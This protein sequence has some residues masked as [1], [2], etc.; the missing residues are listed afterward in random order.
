MPVFISTR[1]MMRLG[2]DPALYTPW[3][4]WFAWYP[5]SEMNCTYW[6]VWVEWRH[7]RSSG[8][9]SD[10]LV[11]SNYIEY[12]TVG[13]VWVFPSLLIRIWEGLPIPLPLMILVVWAAWFWVRLL[14]TASGNLP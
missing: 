4:R 2:F 10:S 14:E 3:K 6:L 9:L 7:V 12:R 13:K 1:P 11:G 5:V 8:R